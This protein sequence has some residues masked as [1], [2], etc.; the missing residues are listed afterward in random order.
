MADLRAKGSAFL[1]QQLRKHAGVDIIYARGDSSTSPR[2]RRGRSTFDVPDLQGMIVHT[3]TDDFF[4]DVADLELDD[5]PVEPKAGDRIT[6]GDCAGSPVYEVMA[7][8]AGQPEWKYTDSYRTAYR[9]HTKFI[10][11]SP[12]A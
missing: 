3:E 7:P 1:A 2:A 5:I 8:G 12:V 11:T 6:V 9:I 4:I 10:G